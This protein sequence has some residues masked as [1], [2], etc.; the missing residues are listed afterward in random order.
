IPPSRMFEI[1][2]AL[3]N[4]K[5][6]HGDSAVTYDASQGDGGASLPGVPV[7]LLERAS[8]LQV[9]HGT[10][11]DQ[12]FGT[13]RFRKAAYENYWQIDAASGWTPQNIAFTQGGRDGL[14]KAY[15]AMISAGHGRIGDLLVVSR[16]PWISYNWGPYSVGLNVL[17]APG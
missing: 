3:D 4:Y 14:L 17:R 1:K 7:E 10:G 11:Y 9:E 16:V 5:Q 2:N 15:S 12:P 13:P 6:T 8:K